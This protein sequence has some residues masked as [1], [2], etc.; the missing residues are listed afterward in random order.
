MKLITTIL[1]VL[2]WTGSAAAHHPGESR[3]RIILVDQRDDQTVVY[4]RLP[5]PLLFLAESA[6]R[7]S[8]DDP[9]VAPFLRSDRRQDI[10]IHTLDRHAIGADRDGFAARIGATVALTIDGAAVTPTVADFAVHDGTQTLPAFETIDDA[11]A[12][13]AVPLDGADPLV[14]LAFIDA[15]LLVD[16]TGDLTI[17]S[18]LNEEAIPA[19]IYIENIVIDYRTDPAQQIVRLGALDQAIVLQRP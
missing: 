6:G 3:M 19:Q 14:G 8:P 4:I 16:G 15:R 11:Q 7:D 9:V 13:L 2:F 10:W 18:A 12:S 17:E 5:A 1:L